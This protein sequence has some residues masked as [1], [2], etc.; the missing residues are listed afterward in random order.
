MAAYAS[1]RL[2]WLALLCALWHAAM[3]M[4]HAAAARPALLAALCSQQGTV[5][6]PLPPKDGDPHVLAALQCPLCLA[7]AHVATL[8]PPVAGPEISVALDLGPAY[9]TARAACDFPATPHL[10]FSPRAP[11]A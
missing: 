9:R 3:P 1:L 7:G 5:A 8:P 11:P 10:H 2:A 6:V 4:A